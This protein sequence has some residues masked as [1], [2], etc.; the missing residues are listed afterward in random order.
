M[1]VFLEENTE[2][3]PGFS[4]GGLNDGVFAAS[5]RNRLLDC[6]GSFHFAGSDPLSGQSN[7]SFLDGHVEAVEYDNP[8]PVV[9]DGVLIRNS[10]RLIF[11]EIPT[12]P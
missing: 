8:E 4:I 12:R 2:V 6:V 11:D 5:K 9:I 7:A 1:A 10:S 3:I